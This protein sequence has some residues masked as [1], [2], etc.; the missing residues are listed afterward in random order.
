MLCWRWSH[1][2]SACNR[3]VWSTSRIRHPRPIPP[4]PA[5]GASRPEFASARRFMLALRRFRAPP[6]TTTPSKPKWNIDSPSAGSCR[7]W[8]ATSPVVWTCSSSID[9]DV[10]CPASARG[11]SSTR[12]FQGAMTALVT[13]MKGG[14]IDEQA[15]RRNVDEQIA[16]GI[17][18]LVAVG[19]TGESPTLSHEEHVNTVRI[20][21]DQA[22]KR[23]PVIA[24]AGSN[25]T[26]EAIDLAKACKKAGADGLLQ[27]TPYYNKPTQDNLFRHF[28][29]VLEAA[30]LPTILYNVPGRTG[31]DLLPDTVARLAEL[32]GI[33]GIKE[34]TG[35]P[36]RAQQIIA[37][38]DG[39]LV[40]ISGDDA[41][42]L[43]LYAVGARG[44]ISVSSNVVPAEIAAMW[45][46]VKAHDF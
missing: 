12:M 22:K 6:P 40:V 46:A 14:R 23:V 5:S 24:G 45:D 32:S 43:S 21:I 19:T 27:V 31:C 39:K 15:L 26:Q 4:A 41:T 17:D 2:S 42:A 1:P 30:P 34:A 8:S 7:R 28:R 18:G 3:C 10:G 44:V 38:C 36:V 25:S 16:A 11:L 33:V 29:A 35:S 9:T 20:V 13:P 37:H